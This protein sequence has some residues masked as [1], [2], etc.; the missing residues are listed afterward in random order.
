[1][2]MLLRAYGID[3]DASSVDNFADAGQHLLYELSGGS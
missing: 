3:P 2:V 1:M